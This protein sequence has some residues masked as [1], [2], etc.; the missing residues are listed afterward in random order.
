M[1]AGLHFLHHLGLMLPKFP[2]GKQFRELYSVCLSGN[3]VCDSEG[4]KESLQLLRMMSLDD[5]CTLLESGVGLIAEWK[6]SSSEIGKL[7]SDVQSF[8]HRLKNIEEEP[9]ESLE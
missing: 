2:L 9:D 8:I 4:Y 7:I 1:F 6:D 3:H 5:L